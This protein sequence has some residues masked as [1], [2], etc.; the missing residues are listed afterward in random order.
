M[1]HIAI[2][3][4]DEV[5][6]EQLEKMLVEMER[7]SVPEQE[8]FN[9]IPPFYRGESFYRYLKEGN[10]VDLVFLDIEFPGEDGTT[11][12]Q[13][14]RESV[15]EETG[16]SLWE[17]AGME[18]GHRIRDEFGE[19]MMMVYISSKT[20]YAPELFW[21]IPRGF[22]KKPLERREVKAVLEGALN[23]KDHGNKRFE[24]VCDGVHRLFWLKDILYFRSEK[25]HVE[26]VTNRMMYK[27]Y[28]KLSEIEETLKDQN[29]LKIH[30]SFFVHV[31][32]V[33]A[34]GHEKLELKN[35]DCI[36]IRRKYQAEVRHFRLN[37]MKKEE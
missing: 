20:E 16:K 21:N 36:P 12:R 33:A 19:E 26:L 15:S 37:G 5:V 10:Q 22:L 1:F 17:A 3:D 18:M 31:N 7:E 23:C 28:M 29:F 30:Q 14:F 35:G 24:C 9:I 2:C 4:D 27:T 6:C 13:L 8:R 25:N 34:W 32:Y 11:G